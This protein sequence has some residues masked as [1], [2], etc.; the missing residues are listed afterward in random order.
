MKV[1]IWNEPNR[2]GVA[3][4]FYEEQPKNCFYNMYTGEREEV[5]KGDLIPEKFIMRVPRFVATEL[6]KNLAEA[7][8]EIG[9]K[10]KHDAR[11]E[12]EL[13]ATK[14]HLED[15]RKILKIK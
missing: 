7:I 14:Y 3:M 13:D 5:E 2:A 9:I 4:V 8:N 15:L 11:I 6:F 1:Q 12:G 10:T